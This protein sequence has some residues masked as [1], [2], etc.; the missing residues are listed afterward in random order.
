MS[1]PIAWSFSVLESFETCPWRHYLTRVTKEVHESQSAEMAHGNRVH[2]SLE[3]RLMQGTP[4]PA[5]LRHYEG[6]AQ[7]MADA[8][9]GGVLEAEQKMAINARFQPTRFFANDVWARGITDVTIVKKTKA[10]IADWKTGNPK[11]NSAQLRLTAAMTFA[12]KPYV[13]T[14][15]NTFIWLKTGEVTRE[16][17]T[18]ADIPA[19]WQE[20]MPRVQ[21]L[22]IAYAETKWPKKPSGL[23]RKWCPVPLSKCEYRGS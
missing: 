10:L 15:T 22:E 16:D 11:P 19:I 5:D 18:K 13:E 6:F 3:D 9:K 23:C 7:R 17:Y 20:F 21:R 14:I 4:L 8:A 12:H 2:K 1:K